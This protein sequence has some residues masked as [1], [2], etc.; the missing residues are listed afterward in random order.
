MK[1]TMEG[2]EW[3]F[4]LVQ[5]HDIRNGWQWLYVIVRQEGEFSIDSYC[6]KHK[7]EEWEGICRGL[8]LALARHS[9]TFSCSRPLRLRVRFQIT[10]HG[11]L[12]Y[13]CMI[14]NR[15]TSAHV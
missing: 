13:S 5:I 6:F 1:V 15:M 10:D 2:L 7:S 9:L 8:H 3:L 12:Q 14:S 11:S 4:R